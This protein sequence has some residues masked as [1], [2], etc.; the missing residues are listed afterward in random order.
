MNKIYKLL[1]LIVIF[2]SVSASAQTF[3]DASLTPGVIDPK[4]TKEMICTKGYTSQKD[5]RKVSLKTKKQV[6]IRY[7]IPWSEHAKYEVDHAVSL[8][9]FGSNSLLNLWPQIY[10]SVGNNPIETNCWGAREKDVVET[11][12]HK[13]FCKDLLTKEQIIHILLKDWVSC[14]KQIKLGKICD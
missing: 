12:V 4:A 8:E 10:C 13:W 6:F 11:K 5:V 7:K 14:Y 2:L 9:N 3:P 1:R